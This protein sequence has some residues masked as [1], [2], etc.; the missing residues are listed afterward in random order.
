MLI[1]KRV[2]V[3]NNPN[4]E[5]QWEA[6]ARCIDKSKSTGWEKGLFCRKVLLEI[7]IISSRIKNKCRQWVA[8]RTW[9]ETRLVTWNALLK[10]FFRNLR[11]KTKGEKSEGKERH[12]GV[13]RANIGV[14]LSGKQGREVTI[15]LTEKD[16]TWVADSVLQACAL[17][18]QCSGEGV[19][20]FGIVPHLSPKTTLYLCPCPQPFH[21]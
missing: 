20:L 5:F 7:K 18:P 1:S 11:K 15:K 16:L 6:R 8:D 19:S 21:P 13:Q 12:R 2:T 9:E 3:R 10:G 4:S 14:S 17:W